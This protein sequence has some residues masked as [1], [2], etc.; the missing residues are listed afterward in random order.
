MGYRIIFTAMSL[1]SLVMLAPGCQEDVR[2]KPGYLRSQ[3]EYQSKS[4]SRSRMLTPQD[5]N[6]GGGWDN[7][8]KSLDDFF[9]GWAKE[10]PAQPSQ[11]PS[12]RTGFS[13][14]I[15][16]GPSRSP[17]APGSGPKTDSR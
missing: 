4:D 12:A 14:P 5:V 7:F 13:G 15:G 3:N 17:D 16:G 10:S 2:A 6:Q 11:P 9:F 1:T 8:T